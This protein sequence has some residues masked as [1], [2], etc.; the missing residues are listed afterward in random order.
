MLDIKP[1]LE[2]K[3][4]SVLASHKGYLYA[5]TTTG[6]L[7]MKIEME[8]DDES[9]FEYESEYDYDEMIEYTDSL[10]NSEASKGHPVCPYHGYSYIINNFISVAHNC[11]VGGNMSNIS[12]NVCGGE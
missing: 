8:E 4:V 3:T 9:E 1:E 11:S 7:K 2:D 10:W 12:V 6:I 5:G